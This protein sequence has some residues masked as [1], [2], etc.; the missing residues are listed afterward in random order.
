VLNVS[1]P[2]TGRVVLQWDNLSS[3]NR[4]TRLTLV[5]ATTGERVSLAARS[6]F[7]FQATA[8]VTRAFQI[9]AEPARSLPLRISSLSVQTSGRGVGSEGMTI[10]YALSEA[11]EVSVQLDTLGGKRVTRM[12]S[13]RA[14]AS[15]LQ[16]VRWNGRAEDGSALPTG[17]YMLTITARAE[18]G[19]VVK[20]VRPVTLIR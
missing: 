15:G 10:A 5:D 17:P 3:V 2:T 18:D 11:A 6:S 12:Y 9:L 16:K 19:T 8:G 1:A 13:G 7:A 20:Q 14:Q 4:K